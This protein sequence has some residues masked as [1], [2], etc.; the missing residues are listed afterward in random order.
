[1]WH[2]SWPVVTEPLVCHVSGKGTKQFP[3]TLL[4]E[5][6]ASI[7][8]VTEPSLHDT[9]PV[10][11][12]TTWPPSGTIT[13]HNSLWIK[14]TE[15]LDSNLYW[16]YGSTCFGQPFCPSSGVLSRTSALVHF[17]QFDDRLLPGAGWNWWWAERLPET[18]RAVIPIKVAIQC[19]CW[20]YSQGI[21]HDA[22]SYV[23][24][25]HCWQTG[26]IYISI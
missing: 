20:F 1:M 12:S 15:A 6:L 21:R 22:R 14:P 17:M 25:I 2:L 9:A 18:C 24:K 3:N 26:K 5:P 16:Y 19:V 10:T 7:S 13:N 8:M 11:V 23:L 4:M